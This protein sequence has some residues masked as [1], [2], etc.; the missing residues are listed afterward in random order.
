[1]E[2]IHPFHS[3]DGTRRL[4][5]SRCSEVASGSGDAQLRRQVADDIKPGSAVGRKTAICI[6]QLWL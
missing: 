4:S 1:L 6:H 5:F 3:F 2:L